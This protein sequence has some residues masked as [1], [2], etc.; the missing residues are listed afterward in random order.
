MTALAGYDIFE[1]LHV[2]ARSTVHRARRRTDQAKVVIKQLATG[3]NT[4][5]QVA[6]FQYGC[7][8]STGLE[9]AGVPRAI[10]AA[11]TDGRPALV[12]EDIDGTSLDRVLAQNRLTLIEAVRIGVS[13]ARTLGQLHQ[14]NI[15][16]RDIKPGNVILA[17]D[18]RVQI[19]DFH[20]ASRLSRERVALEGPETIEG[21]LA[22]IAPEQTGRMNL[23]V[24]YRS[25]LYS[26]GATLFHLLTG[27]PPFQ[28]TD[29]LALVHCHLAVVPETPRSLDANIPEALSDIVT[30]LLAKPPAE[31]Y[32]SAYGVTV[33][34]QTCLSQ[35]EDRG[36]ITPFALGGRDVSA[37]FQVSSRLYGRDAERRRL[38]DA[39]ERVGEGRTGLILIAGYSGIGKSRLVAE[40]QAPIAGRRGQYVEGKFDQLSNAPYAPLIQG[41]RQVTQ[42]LLTLPRAAVEAWRER[43]QEALGDAGQVMCEVL[44]ELEL[45]L[46]PQPPLPELG[47]K[48]ARNRFQHVFCSLLSAVA[49]R[50]HPLVMFVDDLQWADTASLGLLRQ[51][52]ADQTID[53][54]LLIGAYRDNEVDAGHPL[55]VALQEIELTG[56]HSERLTLQPLDRDAVGALIADTVGTDIKGCR[57]L[58]DLVAAKTLGNPF[59]VE[60]FLRAIHASGALDFDAAAGRW[61][62]SLEA[63]QR[64]GI[65]DNVADLMADNVRRLPPETQQ[66]LQLAACIGNRFDLEALALIRELPA[67]AVARALWPALA[68]ELIV[69]I[70][71]GWRVA[72]ADVGSRTD[73]RYRFL[74]DRVQAA[75]YAL[76]PE[77]ERIEVHLRVGRLLRDHSADVGKRLFDVVRHLNSGVELIT[78]PAERAQ[79]AGLNLQAGRKARAAGA[80]GPARDYLTAGLGCLNAEAWTS[81]YAVTLALHSDAAE[82]AYLTGD[83]D[84]LHQLITHAI[85]HA[86]LPR[87]VASLYEVLARGQATLGA[88]QKAVHTALTGLSHLGM[89]FPKRPGQMHVVSGLLRTKLRL[90]G[91]STAELANRPE[92]TDPDTLCALRLMGAVLAA[93]YQASPNHLPLFVFEIIRLSLE[94]G[95]TPISSYAYTT[96]GLILVAALEDVDGG[97]MFGD[98]ANVLV[99]Q[100][101]A[102][103][104]LPKVILIENAFIRH[105]QRPPAE[106]RATLMAGYRV[107]RET[108][109]LEYASYC[110]GVSAQQMMATGEPLPNIVAHVDRFADTIAGEAGER[111]A[112]MVR[113]AA[114]NLQRSPTDPLLICGPRYDERTERAK[115]LTNNDQTALANLHTWK[116]MLGVFCDRNAE[117]MEHAALAETHLEGVQAAIQVPLF[118][119]YSG[120]ARLRAIADD[121]VSSRFKVLRQVKGSVRKLARWAKL[122]ARVHRH[123]WLIL[124]AQLAVVQGKSERADSL[125][126]KALAAAETAG[127][128][129]DLGLCYELAMRHYQATSRPAP[130]GRALEAA[131]EAYARW[132]AATVV[133]RLEASYPSL[134]RHVPTMAETKTMAE[135]TTNA[136]ASESTQANMLDVRSIIKATQVISSEIVLSELLQSLMRTVLENAGAQRGFLLLARDGKLSIRAR[137]DSTLGQPEVLDGLPLEDADGLAKSIIRYVERSS[138]QVVL[139]DATTDE[140]FN[141]DP[142]VLRNAV[143]SVLAM[144]IRNQNRQIGVL[145]LENNAAHDAFTQERC[146]VLSILSAQAAISLENALLYD[147]QERLARSLAR[148]VPT[149]FLALL[150]K[151]SILDVSLGDAVEREMGVLFADIRSFTSITEGM[152]PDESFRFVNG[153]L[154]RMGPIIREHGGFIDKYLGD[155]VMALFPGSAEDALHT[156]VA[157]H[158]TLYEHRPRVDVGVGLHFG[159]VMLGTIGEEQRLDGTV[160]SDVVNS[161]SRLEGLTKALGA[162]ILVSGELLSRI[163]D[164]RKYAHRWLGKVVLKGKTEVVDVYE[165][166]CAD[167]ADMVTHKEATRELMEGSVRL[168]LDG[169]M[170]RAEAGFTEVL[171][172]QPDDVAAAFYLRRSRRHSSAGT[173]PEG[174]LALEFK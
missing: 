117:A 35:L 162:R 142:H 85:E 116:L 121:E 148:F 75:A 88:L 105:W 93:S 151:Y 83:S 49:T 100:L 115:H 126:D 48:E 112:Q 50:E 94:Q 111:L 163:P 132:G 12:M 91:L 102:R 137:I 155:A 7:D 107:G 86:K 16:H 25:D 170:D 65:T 37:R 134:K 125:F 123:R 1:E 60:Q 89:R 32:Q 97:S 173:R 72:D 128:V 127:Y 11:S 122:N 2:G 129:Q 56:T 29:P 64:V 19:I 74:H 17:P 144:P 42:S 24:D 36:Q 14:R 109:D 149:A 40:I 120:L 44:P 67:S 38:L 141:T 61:S 27:R 159:S 133:E 33:D 54:L 51:I 87:E 15:L 57:G 140:R 84:A 118:H 5:S 3:R 103:A 73:A 136:T 146:N 81:D 62:W 158:E 55:L 96:Y 58:T 21:T 71:G 166:Y 39:F 52:L 161:A 95:N 68:E 92:A 171:E 152:T 172:S 20:L 53:A 30:R 106:L 80:F 66:A 26:L 41:V 70:G 139:G 164:P 160:I 10:G 169:A 143:R 98:L 157:M 46:G 99:D 76:I 47:P 59:F 6:R 28:D 130:A 145:Y 23:P 34:L 113:N 69:P 119:L 18:G 22:Y 114:D 156:A 9:F 124:A 43:L 108:G 153:Y 135:T 154:G 174:G 4:P 101:D 8:I 45:I 168:F 165:V 131:A 31:R 13:V 104:Y 78:K 90:R 110:I 150:G 167:P 63:I 138:Q 79:L 147:Q 82:A 77:K